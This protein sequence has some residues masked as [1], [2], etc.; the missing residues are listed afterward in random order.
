MAL[1]CC[2]LRIVTSGCVQ[3]GLCNSQLPGGARG[4]TG[5][6]GGVLVACAETGA[7]IHYRLC[8]GLAD[9]L[10][11]EHHFVRFCARLALCYPRPSLD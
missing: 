1:Q 11:P 4:H 7:P 9:A 2:R 3:A 8:H 5:R 6:T 10:G